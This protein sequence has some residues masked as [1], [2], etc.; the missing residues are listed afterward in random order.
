[1][2]GTD[3]D[4]ER[5]AVVDADGTRGADS[6]QAGSADGTVGTVGTVE[7]DGTDDATEQPGMPM[8]EE[9]K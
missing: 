4:T 6:A 2:T 5:V 8:K 9:L 3:V 7:A 1:L